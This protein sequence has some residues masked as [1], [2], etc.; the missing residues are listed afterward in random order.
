MLASGVLI[1]RRM[2]FWN[3]KR[4]FVNG[5]LVTSWQTPNCKLET[6][7]IRMIAESITSFLL[8]PMGSAARFANDKLGFHDDVARRFDAVLH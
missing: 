6:E 5:L 2:S 3:D 1:G 8:F 4:Y 7:I